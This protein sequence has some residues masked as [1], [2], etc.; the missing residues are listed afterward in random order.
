VRTAA[1]II[2]VIIVAGLG[3]VSMDA[4]KTASEVQSFVGTSESGKF[5]DLEGRVKGNE[6]FKMNLVGYDEPDVDGEG[7]CQNWA[8]EEQTECAK[9]HVNGRLEAVETLAGDAKRIAGEA[10]TAASTEANR[11]K[12]EAKKGRQQLESR[13]TG[14]V[15]DVDEKVE[16]NRR[17]T[18]AARRA[19]R[20]TIRMM[21]RKKLVDLEVDAPKEDRDLDGVDDAD[22]GCPDE[23]GLDGDGCVPPVETLPE[24]PKP[25]PAPAP[26][27]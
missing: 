12:E 22:D 20:R 21:E 8:N 27:S 24:D 15:N 25:A 26:T 19:H 2:A 16:E 7:V 11:V 1:A 18:R 17:R 13:M 3:Y 9:R 23:T 5:A 4:Y 14:R 10:K 6:H